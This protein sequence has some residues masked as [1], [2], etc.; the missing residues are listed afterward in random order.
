[1]G[2]LHCAHPAQKPGGPLTMPVYL[3]TQDFD[4]LIAVGSYLIMFLCLAGAVNEIYA[5]AHGY[6]RWR[7]MRLMKGKH[8]K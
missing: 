1:M 5:L 7:Q 6:K 2:Q 3:S 8:K 4:N